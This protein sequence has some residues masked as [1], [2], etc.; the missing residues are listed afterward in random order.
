MKDLTPTWNLS[1]LYS[2]INDPQIEKDRKAILDLT[3][4]FIKKYKGTINSKKLTAKHMLSAQRD[5]EK[6]AEL[7]FK[8]GKFAHLIHDVNIN[9]PEIGKFYAQENEFGSQIS[10]KLLWFG[11]EWKQVPDEI[12]NKILNDPIL[13]DYRHSLAHS[14]VFKPFMKSEP[15]EIIIEKLEQT[16]SDAFVRLYDET[17]TAIRYKLEVKGKTKELTASELSVYSTD[18]DRE[19]RK[20]AS[21]SLTAGLETQKKN[22]TFILNTLLLDK[23]IADEIRGF[24][25]PQE[26]T[27]LSYE[28]DK[29]IVEAMSTAIARRYSI[30]ARYY[31]AKKNLLGYDSLHEW[32]TYCRIFPDEKLKYSWEKAEDTVITAFNK[33]TPEFAN[34]ASKFFDN[35]WI[36]AKLS[37]DKVAG[38]YCMYGTPSTHPNVLMN[39]TG[40]IE[41]V[42]TLAHELG[43]GI[44]A[45]LAQ[46][47]SLSQSRASTA[48]AEI[49]SVFA[50]SLAFDQLYS[51]IDDTQTKIN[52]LAN[53]IQES[54]ATVFVQNAYYLFEQ[55]INKHRRENG[56]LSTEEYDQYFNKRIQEMYG[57]SLKLSENY[58][59][60][61][62]RVSHFYQFNFYIFTYCMGELLT[63]AL[64]G[65][66]KTRR[67][68]S[69]IKSYI[70]A[71]SAGGSLSPYE[72]MKLMGVDIRKP[73][74]WNTGLDLLEN[75]VAEFENLAKNV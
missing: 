28:V 47:Q 63:L 24:K 74:F 3:E 26:A 7:S 48:V 34:T 54:I 52:L 41:D 72:I 32:D 44:H 20:A 56:E 67:D 29:D 11:L 73:E 4:Q 30:A 19:T 36:D 46:K 59:N 10:S 18:P 37:G 27:F 21:L 35:R 53:K 57:D 58:R 42:N 71:L 31:K 49:A 61:W 66:Y 8:Y 40:R 64:F 6:I 17:E 13:K 16:G 75:Y 70:E 50:E 15:E 43:H 25:Y 39:F 68:K 5:S 9:S 65:E 55:D 23:K 60:R 51:T 62:M 38:A 2:G 69:F 14:R 22:F 1:D 12:A 45:V 33:F